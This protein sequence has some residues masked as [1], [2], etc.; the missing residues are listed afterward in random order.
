MV[1]SYRKAAELQN[2]STTQ[3]VIGALQD[4]AKTSKLIGADYVQ[5]KTCLTVNDM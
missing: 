3:R 2:E 4:A 1:I 5:C